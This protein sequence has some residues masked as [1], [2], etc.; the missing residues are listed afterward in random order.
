MKFNLHSSLYNTVDPQAM[1][2]LRKMLEIDPHSRIP[3][4]RLI[5]HPFFTNNETMVD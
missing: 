4:S 1:D 2:L 3:A 5:N